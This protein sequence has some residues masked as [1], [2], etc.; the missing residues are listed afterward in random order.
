M[1]TVTSAD[2]TTIAFDQLGSGP[3]LVLVAGASC[4]RG[5]DQPIAEALARDFTVLNHDRRGRGDSGD[6]TTPATYEV[7]REIEDLAVLLD[8]AGGGA[9]LVGLSSG[10]ALAARAA[11]AGLPVRH[12][13]M[14]EPPFQLD[15]AGQQASLEYAQ[16]LRGLLA[17]DRRGDALALFMSIAGVPEQMVAGIRQSP[18]WPVGE[19]LAHTLAYDAAVM[20]DASVPVAYA[21]ITCPTLVLT[22]GDSP[23]FF[24]VGAEAAAAV[25]P[26]GRAAVLDGQTHNV[27]A[28]VL[29]DA[30]RD[31]TTSVGAG[32]TS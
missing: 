23:P 16:K 13:V 15:P 25:V 24:A 4:D 2:G 28:D 12:L 27:A 8:A 30:V 19:G 32:G 21:D 10:A 29:A 9:V 31:F 11:V 5:Q 18:W 22:G 3:P 1:E 26:G 7:D 20:G 17:E 14:W 6:A